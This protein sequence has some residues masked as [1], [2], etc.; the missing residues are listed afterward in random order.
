MKFVPKLSTLRSPLR[1]SLV[2]KSV[3]QWDESHTKAFEELK[4]QFVYIT[5]NNHFNIKKM[6]RLKTDD[7]HSGL[8]ATLEQ[9]D[10]ENW[11]TIAF[12][13]RF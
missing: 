5:E 6:S 12:A 10:G 8:G 1:P 11:L 3:Y 7:S 2:K 13:S 9:R 4:R